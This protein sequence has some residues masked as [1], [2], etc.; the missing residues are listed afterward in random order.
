MIYIKRNISG[1]YVEF[2]QPLNQEY[3]EIGCT[4]E[5]FIAGK[6]IPLTYDQIE[7]HEDNPKASIKEVID[8]QLTSVPEST[9]EELLQQAKYRKLSELHNYDN[10]SAVNEFSINGQLKTWF[11]PSERSNYKNSIDSAKLLGINKLQFLVDET[12]IEIPTTNAAQL[13]A[14]IQL[15]ADTCYVVTKQHEAAINTL[16]TV[17]EVEDYD[18]TVDYPE[19]LNFEL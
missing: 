17:E 7:F 14:R 1:Y 18:F 12:I 9:K 13:L 2:V 10:S 15:Y 5:D 11:I 3:F 16:K 4:Y 8:M 19:K 6:W